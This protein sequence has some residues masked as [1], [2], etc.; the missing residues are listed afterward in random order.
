[1]KKD[2][3][4]TDQ[5]NERNQLAMF[6]DAVRKLPDVMEQFA[7]G[8]CEDDEERDYVRPF[9][10]QLRTNIDALCDTLTHA[11]A[12]ASAT[13]ISDATASLRLSTGQSLVDRGLAMSKS[14]INPMSKLALGDIFDLVKKVVEK[15]GY[16]LFPK[17]ME[18]IGWIFEIINEIKGFFFGGKKPASLKVYADRHVLYMAQLTQ[19]AKLENAR[20][21]RLEEEDENSLT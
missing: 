2:E 15:V 16:K 9:G 3:V 12:T 19:L 7:L 20:A 10:Q 8:T 14:P 1:M 18:K 21:G 13:Q 5:P 17:L 6:F 4:S 11:L